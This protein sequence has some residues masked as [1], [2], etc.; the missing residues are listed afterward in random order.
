MKIPDIEELLKAGVHFGHKTS[1]WHPAMEPYIFAERKGIHIIDLHKT[2]IE[3]EKAVNFIH[4]VVSEQGKI[5]FIGTKKQAQEKIVLAAQKTQM[6]FVTVKWIS[7][8]L[9]NWPIIKKQIL[10]LKK[11]REEKEKNEWIKYTKKEQL[12]LENSL[13]TLEEFYG[14][15]SSLDRLP[16]A[17]FITDCKVSKTAIAE[18]HL[19]NIPIIALCDTNVDV[20]KIDYPIPANDDAVKA[21]EIIINTVSDAILDG[22]TTGKTEVKA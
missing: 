21:L 1:K 17:L 11:R 6:P 12:L 4:K 7:G 20:R 13:K 16:E 15:I 3:L 9:T 5:L 8:T 22:R 19:K 2:R 14:G 10:K 18:A